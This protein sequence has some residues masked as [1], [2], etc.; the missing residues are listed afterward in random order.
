[1]D[2]WQRYD[3][4]LRGSSAPRGK[5]VKLA[6]DQLLERGFVADRIEFGVVLCGIRNSSDISTALRRCSSAS[7]VRPH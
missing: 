7:L 3:R 1:M 4:L 2:A 5:P 6:A